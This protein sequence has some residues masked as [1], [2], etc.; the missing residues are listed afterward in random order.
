MGE[1]AL[2][3]LVPG[4]APL[5]P[6]VQ[7]FVDEEAG[8]EVVQKVTRRLQHF[9]DRKVAAAMEPLL[10]LQKDETLTGLAKGF[11]YRLVEHSAFFRA[12]RWQK[13]SRPWIRRRGGPCASWGAVRPVH[14]VSAPAAQACAHNGCVWCCG[15]WPRAW[16]SFQPHRR[17]AMSRSWPRKRRR[18]GSMR[19]RATGPRATARSASTC[20]NVWPISCATRTAGA[21]LKP[22]P[23]CCRSQACHPIS[24]PG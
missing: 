20:W 13:R 1:H 8:D 3:K 4:P 15:G 2:G 6:D 22:R 23:T 10:A 7:A 12:A 17:P 18:M 11:A 21:A 14:R 24:L 5:R 19:C 16:P 9:V